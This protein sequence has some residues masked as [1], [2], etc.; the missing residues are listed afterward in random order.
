MNVLRIN[1]SL[2]AVILSGLVTAYAQ[3]DRS[4][5][6][7]GNSSYR[8]N[9][10]SDAEVSYRKALE[11]NRETRE[12][13]FNLG[14]ALYKQERF[15]EA[16]EQYRTATT[17]LQDAPTRAKAYHNLGNAL[18]KDQKLTESIVA[19][20]DGLKLN[21]NDLETKYNLEYAKALLKEQQKNPQQ[22]NKQKKEEKEKEKQKQ[23]RDKQDQ[24]KQDQQQGKQDQAKQKEPRESQGKKQQISKEDT[25]RILEALRN[26][27][28]AVQKK[29]Q[30]KTPARVN[31]EK[32]W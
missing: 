12:G 26:E 8:E 32:D 13:I 31:I 11:K 9:K 7:D 14:D 25:E 18:L 17:K 29:L 2:I 22:N 27:E 10:F 16:A 23:E 28:K 30:K 6:R 24:Q 19:Y 21:P 5:V 3:S 15:A 20:K 1:S 4:L